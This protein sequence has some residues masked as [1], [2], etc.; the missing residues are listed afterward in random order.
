MVYMFMPYMGHN[1]AEM[2]LRETGVTFLCFLIKYGSFMY[3]SIHLKSKLYKTCVQ[4]WC[5][6][7]RNLHSQI[8]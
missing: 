4:L 3:K 2:C 1:Q 7:K 8:Y 6:K 5:I